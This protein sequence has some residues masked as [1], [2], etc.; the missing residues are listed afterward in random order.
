MKRKAT[1]NIDHRS[2][3]A[4]RRVA[5]EATVG[6]GIPGT[7]NTTRPVKFADRRAKGNKNEARGRTYRGDD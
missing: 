7:R 2:L 1:S 4:A 6:T 3:A 5:R